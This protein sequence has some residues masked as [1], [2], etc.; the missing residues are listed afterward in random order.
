MALTLLRCC[1]TKI[2]VSEEKQTELD[3]IG[4]QCPGV[5]T[6]EYAIKFCGD[7]IAELPNCAAAYFADTPAAVSG[8]GKGTLPRE[9]SLASIDNKNIHVTAVKTADDKDGVVLRM[10]NPNDNAEA[11]NIGAGFEVKGIAQCDLT[12]TEVANIN[13]DVDI[14]AKKIFTV[15][16]K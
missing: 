1:R 12:E 14:A 9:Y 11:I 16:I 6:V 5:H 2:A 10:Y 4:I 15:K 8:R 13:A 3:D 7:N